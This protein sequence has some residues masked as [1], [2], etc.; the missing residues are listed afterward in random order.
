MAHKGVMATSRTVAINSTTAV[1]VLAASA[2]RDHAWLYNDSAISFRVGFGTDTATSS[3]G[4]RLLPGEDM[5]IPVELC[6]SLI[7]VCSESG[8]ALSLKVVP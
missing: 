2:G 1:T 3:N 6:P 5:L 8:A 4:F 7:T